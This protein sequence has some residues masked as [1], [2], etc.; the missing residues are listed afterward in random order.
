MKKHVNH[1]KKAV[2]ILVFIAFSTS[3]YAQNFTDGVI[4]SIIVTPVKLNNF[5]ANRIEKNVHLNWA[6]TSEKNN[7]HFNIQRSNNGQNFETIGKVNPSTTFTYQFIDANAPESN[8]Y[9]R[10]E[11][12]DADG[13]TSLSEVVLV[14][15]NKISIDDWSIYPNPIINKLVNISFK[16]VKANQYNISLKNIKGETI[17][18]KTININNINHNMLLQLPATITKGFYLLNLL[19]SDGSINS[20]KKILVN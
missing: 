18:E 8:L 11:N 10:L 6:T 13:K 15:F 20:T 19:S 7:S 12:V 2:A 17:F 4:D 1:Y 16:N 9:Y 14:K 5:S 3:N